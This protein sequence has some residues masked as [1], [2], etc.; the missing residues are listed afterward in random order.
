MQSQQ[1]IASTRIPMPTIGFINGEVDATKAILETEDELV[2]PVIVYQEVVLLYL[3]GKMYR[4]AQEVQESLF[5][6]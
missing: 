3:K 4:S 1:L 5:T 2:I 6:C